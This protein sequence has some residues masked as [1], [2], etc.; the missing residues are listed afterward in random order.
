MEVKYHFKIVQGT[1]CDIIAGV[2]KRNK[3][4][5]TPLHVAAKRREVAKVKELLGR[6]VFVGKRT[7]VQMPKFQ[8]LQVKKGWGLTLI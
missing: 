6:G 4:G 3:F 2:D 8:L 5:E 1:K 7:E